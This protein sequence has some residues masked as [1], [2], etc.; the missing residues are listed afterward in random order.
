MKQGFEWKLKDVLMVGINGVLFSILYLGMVYLGTFL[1]GIMTPFGLGAAG[2]EPIFGIWFMAGIF[3][4]Y[5]IQKPG[6][7]LVAEMLA[8]LLEV[9][10]GNMF[11]PTVFIT[12]MVHGLGAELGFAI[13]HYKKYDMRSVLC[14][15]L[16]CT[17]LSFLWNTWNSQYYLLE[18]RI[19][20][21]MVVIRLISAVIFGG[22]GS[23]LLAD[24]LARAG[25]LKGY[26]LG[27]NRGLD[28]DGDEA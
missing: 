27:Q 8:A 2:Y 21:I 13:F 14:S 10:M 11:G 12:G 19:I 24:G 9:L 22:I 6:V 7:G 3:T 25:V 16:F 1:T 26:A 4:V 18:G 17:V 15:S 23:K 20:A 5:V 28:L